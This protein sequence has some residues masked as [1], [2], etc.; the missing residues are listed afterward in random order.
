MT[1]ELLGGR[2][3][4]LETVG[5]GGMAVVYRSK[6]TLLNR[7]VA[8][9]VLR[10]QF[11]SD[12]E[13]RER[14]R[15]EAQSA[16]GLSHPNVVNVYDVGEEAGSNY[17]VMEWVN[18]L[19]LHDV[20]VRDGKL[21]VDQAVNVT[22]Q[23]LGAL[24]HAHSNGIIHRDI[25]PHNILINT[26]G[27]VKVADFGIARAA[28]ASALTETG[29]V[30][31]TVNYTSPEQARGAA[32][33]AESDIY[34]LGVVM[35]E[36]L[37]GKLPF[38]GD[39]QVAVAL[40][41]IQDEPMPPRALNP[42]MP[43]ELERVILRA[44]EKDPERRWRTA[45]AFR[46]G[47]SQAMARARQ[48]EPGR[49][50]DVMAI[51]GQPVSEQASVAN[52]LPTTAAQNPLDTTRPF[53][54]AGEATNKV[55][56]DNHRRGSKP[57]RAG[58]LASALVVLLVLAGAAAVGLKAFRDWIQVAEV[59]VPG[60]VGMTLPDAE[61]TARQNRLTLDSSAKRYDDTVDYNHII[62]QDPPQ[63]TKRKVNSVVRVTVSLGPEMVTVPDLFNK[64]VR[65]AKFELEGMRLSLGEQKTGY[66]PDVS[67]GKIIAQEPEVGMY[68]PKGSK[69]DITLSS[70]PPPAPAEIPLVI[71]MTLDQAREAL[72][73]AGY[74]VGQVTSKF[75][76]LYEAG[77]VVEQRPGP[78]QQAE[79]GA[80]VDLVLAE[81]SGG[82]DSGSDSSPRKFEVSYQ[83][84]AG[85]EVQEVM[86]K[87][88]D[89][90]GER[91]SYGPKSHR[92]GDSI[93][94]VVEVYGP[95][96]IEVWVDGNLIRVQDV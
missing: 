15:R 35:Y 87:V 50:G 17:I 5:E 69:V 14:F 36:I 16:A 82:G 88:I 7:I 91:I 75:S 9:K 13:F 94:Y 39:T 29:T 8:V 78:Y 2:Y 83:V 3:S 26:E 46:N 61:S 41:H 65:E 53:G 63:G 24:E 71:G 52:D 86:L 58:V 72:G 48:G 51:P 47:I 54:V 23:I 74:A 96:K 1:N 38:A 92:P 70:G 42:A 21:T 93:R 85:P 57:R 43:V 66:H 95:G 55:A 49:P 28:S 62:D 30:I 31:G 11:A 77:T 10:P 45:R 27:R 67:T 76:I 25:K 6:D 32:A 12:H 56:N 73:R 34:S 37:T 68:V 40:K 59:A 84:P 81:R 89:S 60:F 64:S 79:P 44:L 22:E 18:G 19:T 20:I 80:A 33:T 90:Y 4:L